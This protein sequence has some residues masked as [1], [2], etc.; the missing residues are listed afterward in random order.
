LGKGEESSADTEAN[1]IGSG[2]KENRSR[3]AGAVGEDTGGEE[4]RM[5][6]MAIPTQ[7]RLPRWLEFILDS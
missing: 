1:H 5:F 2:Q 6:E 7:R 4:V 3:S